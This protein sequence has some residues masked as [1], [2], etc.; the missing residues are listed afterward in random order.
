[1]TSSIFKIFKKLN[2]KIL[3]IIIIIII[4]C[5]YLLIK[6]TIEENN[7]KLSYNKNLNLELL[8]KKKRAAKLHS[9]RVL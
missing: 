3:I 7:L 9:K 1:M 4:I 2:T 6:S 8:K 5:G